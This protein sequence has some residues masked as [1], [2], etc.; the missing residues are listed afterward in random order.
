M[1]DRAD[2]AVARFPASLEAAVRAAVRQKL[3]DL[4]TRGIR[5]GRVRRGLLCPRGSPR[6]GM[7]D[8][9]RAALPAA[10]IPRGERGLRRRRLGQALRNGARGGRQRHHHQRPPCARQ[11]G[12]LRLREP[13]SSRDGTAARQTLDAG[14][15][16]S[17]CATRSIAHPGGTTSITAYGGTRPEVDEILLTDL[18]AGLA[19]PTP[20]NSR[21]PAAAARES[22]P[23]NA[24]SCSSPMPWATA[25]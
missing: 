9:H 4:P 20:R 3:A 24:R 21:R 18:Q 1:I 5:L 14:S 19:R 6:R 11:H 25:S 12:D 2:R 7:R 8:P 13:L 16:P 15:A 22:A 23:R 17:S 10:G